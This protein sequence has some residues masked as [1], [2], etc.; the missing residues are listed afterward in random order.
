MKEL[1]E[2]VQICINTLEII[3][4][5][6]T[7]NNVNHML[8]IY[9]LLAEV[10]DQLMAMKTEEKTDGRVDPAGEQEEAE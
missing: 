9:R 5:P 3:N 1:A 2:K 4:V 6:N 7:F 8:G 10:R